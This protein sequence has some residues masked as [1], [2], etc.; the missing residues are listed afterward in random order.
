MDW[1]CKD[2][3]EAPIAHAYSLSGSFEDSSDIK[4]GESFSLKGDTMLSIGVGKDDGTWMNYYIYIYTGKPKLRGAT[5]WAGATG[6]PI[7]DNVSYDTK[8]VSVKSSKSDVISVKKGKT[9]DKCK[10]TAKK[11]GKSTI[12][13]ELNLNGE[14]KKVKATY[15]VKK[16]PN[17][18]KTL[19]VDG[20]SVNFKKKPFEYS[21][22]V[23]KDK[24]KVEFKAG[25]GWKFEGGAYFDVSAGKFV[26]IKSGSKVKVPKGK[27]VTVFLDMVNKKKEY[28]EYVVVLK[29]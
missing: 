10:F 11:A 27:S 19:K 8:V 29:R 24:V 20:K 2:G 3:W 9:L 13:I 28:F 12:T 7:C 6:F 18:L 23:S 15:T 16:Y 5:Y 14:K 25:S 1:A 26:T 22:K 21:T 4:S 17:A